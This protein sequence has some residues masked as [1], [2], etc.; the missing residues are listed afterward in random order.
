MRLLFLIQIKEQHT[1][2]C[3]F[4]IPNRILCALF[5][6]GQLTILIASFGQHIYSY[7][8]FKQIF[9]C[10]SDIPVNATLEEKFMAW[11]VV[12]YDFGLM[13][14]ILGTNEC[15]A[16]YLDGGYMRAM[17]CLEQSAA[18]LLMMLNLS[19][20]QKIVW[21]MWPGLL[22]ES[23]Y[24]LGMSILTMAT[25][26]KILEAMGS[27]A[28]NDLAM[29]MVI[30]VTGFILNWMF[31]LVMWHYYW[32]IESIYAPPVVVQTVPKINR[33]SR[34]SMS[35]HVSAASAIRKP[36]PLS[37]DLES[38]L[39]LQSAP[40]FRKYKNESRC[41]KQIMLNKSKNQITNV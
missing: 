36:P 30:Y 33:K 24:A 32:H 1:I 20:C 41:Q 10:Q 37:N 3:G 2:I 5:G 40:K 4:S 31:T 6:L 23:S 17:W 39:L 8:K 16:N 13:H 11:D 26:P 38:S 14:T 9:H 22:M 28:N 29:A 25:A 21:L 12:I 18:L 34:T 27:K 15:I 7:I 35:L 19:C